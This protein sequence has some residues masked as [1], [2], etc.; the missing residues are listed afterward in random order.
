LAAF[1]LIVFLA[2][3]GSHAVI[4]S[5]HSSGDGQA[6]S[7]HESGHEDPCNSLIL[8]SDSNRKDQQMP[9]LGHDAT[10]HNALFDRQ[11]GLFAQ[12][13]VQKDPRIPFTTEHCIFRPKSPP[14]HPPELS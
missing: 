1:F 8:C 9:N 3:V 6:I 5:N 11:R 4:C 13:I 7:S 2:E 14:F 10:Q 12:T